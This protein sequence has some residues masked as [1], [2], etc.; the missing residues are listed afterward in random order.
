METKWLQTFIVAAAY[1]NFRKASEVLYVT[2]P[3]VT[4]HIKRLEDYLQVALFERDGKRVT[5]SAAGVHFLPIA[6]SMV[7]EVERGL[8][9]FDAW[10]QG[11]TQ[12][13]TIAAA[14]QIASSIL[15]VMVKK[16]MEQSPEIEL[17]V[18]VINSYDVIA[19][20]AKGQAHIGFTRTY[21]P[22]AS[23]TCEIMFEEPVVFVAPAHSAVEQEADV[24]HHYRLITDNHPVYWDDLLIEV[25]R[26]YPNVKVLK[27]NQVEVSKRFIEQGLGVSYLPYSMVEKEVEARTMKL[28]GPKKVALPISQTYVV[29]KIITPEVAN[30]IA[31]LKE[32]MVH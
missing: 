18:H 22:Q 4:N 20:V 27:V 8:R 23:V 13:L 17:L 26:F 11:Y 7:A 6:K 3:A 9:K 19:E 31:F 21:T 2:Q 14:P 16:F 15:P 12:Q 32:E 25:K 10:K 1:E 24:F 30:F 28:I 29:T 5:L